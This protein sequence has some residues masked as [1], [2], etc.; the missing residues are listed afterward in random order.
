MKAY[1]RY[2]AKLYHTGGLEWLNLSDHKKW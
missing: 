2:I 1:L